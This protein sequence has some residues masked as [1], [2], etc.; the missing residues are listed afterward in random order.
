V[1][2]TFICSSLEPGRDGVGDYTRVLGAALTDRGHAVQLVA[3]HDRHVRTAAQSGG[4]GT[5]ALRLP[6]S[7][8][9]S[10]RVAAARR[11]VDDFAPDWVSV[12]FVAY[13]FQDRGH[14]FGLGPRLRAIAAG[15]P[16]HLMFHELWTGGR[17]ATLRQR[18]EGIVQK[19]LTLRFARDLAPAVVHTHAPPYVVMLRR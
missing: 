15:R 5:A 19:Q 17:G 1:K 12:Q 3:L 11:F 6:A 4:G 18:A 10:T 9:W 2:I 16:R 7:A 13:G 8:A 14:V